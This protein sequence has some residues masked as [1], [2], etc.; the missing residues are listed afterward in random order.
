MKHVLALTLML[1]VASSLV[2]PAVEKHKAAY[3]GGTVARFNAGGGR[4]G[5]RI[6][7]SD[8][9]RL[10]FVADEH[11]LAD[12]PPRVEY[13]AMHHIEF[14][15]NARRRV[16]ATALLGP[17]GLLAL[18]SKQRTHHLTVTYRD[19]LGANQVAVLE[20]GKSIVRDTLAVIEARSGKAIEYQDEEARK[21]SK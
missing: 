5:G 17:I 2:V 21:W 15:Q 4:I 16:N 1:V 18:R 3:A 11:P 10:V 7:T 20:L 12:M 8:P 13:A 9:D 19:D 6:D 14:G